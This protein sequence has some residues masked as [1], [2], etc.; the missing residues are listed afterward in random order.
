MTDLTLQE[1]STAMP[2]NIRTKVD[3]S[4]VDHINN[5][6]GDPEFAE[7]YKENL[8]SYTNVM[9]KGKFKL[10][11]YVDA[12]RYVSFKL[13]NETN[14]ESYKRTFPDKYATWKA[15]GVDNDTIAKYVSSYNW[16]KLVQL[17]W[18]QAMTPFLLLNQANRQEAL[19]I[20]LH[21]AR[22]SKSDMVKTTAANSILNH[23]KPPEESKTELEISVKDSSAL[24]D[25][26]SV[27]E[28]MAAR[29]HAAMVGGKRTAKDVARQSLTIEGEAQHE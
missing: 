23:L 27:V 21:L 12:V 17:I 9:E 13:L 1:L 15:N 7:Q 2:A 18:Q 11:A 28:S 14:L 3:Q 24:N 5:I 22:T 4:L 20:Q 10:T 16:G 8:I 25:L 29:E 26:R 6:I 19:N